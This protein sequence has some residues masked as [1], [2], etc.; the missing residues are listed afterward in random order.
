MKRGISQTAHKEGNTSKIRFKLDP[1]TGEIDDAAF[2]KEEVFMTFR[3]GDEADVADL[4]SLE[5]RRQRGERLLA[6][7]PRNWNRIAGVVLGVQH[8]KV[9]LNLRRRMEKHDE[10]LDAAA[11]DAVAD[12]RGSMIRRH[13]ASGDL[14]KSMRSSRSM[15][16]DRRRRNTSMDSQT[17]RALARA[18]QSMFKSPE[19]ARRQGAV[20][21]DPRSAE[22]KQ[23]AGSSLAGRRKMSLTSRFRKSIS[24]SRLK[25]G[26]DQ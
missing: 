22:Q 23:A 16:D 5:R 2:E 14:D 11:A 9:L 7:S 17:G 24:E 10:K 3:S 19:R 8:S 20:T 6:Q 1:D 15:V 13:D 26:A 12:K 4:H 25:A 21:I 18:G